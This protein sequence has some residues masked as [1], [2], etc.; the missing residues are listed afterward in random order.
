MA[1]APP[2]SCRP[3]G[4]F[5]VGAYAPTVD[6]TPAPPKAPQCDRCR[7]VTPAATCARLQDR[8]SRRG[9]HTFERHREIDRR[10]PVGNEIREVVTAANGPMVKQ[11]DAKLA[12]APSAATRLPVRIHQATGPSGC[13]LQA[14]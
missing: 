14:Q 2:A 4:A 13:S 11:S 10:G 6:K 1:P 12:A 8:R 7:R 3:A 5:S 9:H